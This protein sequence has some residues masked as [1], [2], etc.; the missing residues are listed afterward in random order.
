MSAASAT[1][2]A[3]CATSAATPTVICG[4][5][6]GAR[7]KAQGTA[8]IATWTAACASTIATSVPRKPRGRQ[9]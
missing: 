6:W 1:A 2:A 4:S 5:W 3:A 8:L 9:R 7:P